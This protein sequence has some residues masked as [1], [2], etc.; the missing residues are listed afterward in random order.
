MTVTGV[1]ILRR[2]QPDRERPYRM[3]GYPVTPILFAS[4]SFWFVGNTLVTTPGSS[5][6]GL[7]IIGT[8]IPVYFCWRSALPTP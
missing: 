2:T 6:L 5:I 1:L 7:A 4:V 8:G 3:W